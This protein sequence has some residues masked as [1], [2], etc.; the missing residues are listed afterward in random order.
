MTD[1]N[2]INQIRKKIGSDLLL[3][4]SVTSIVMDTQ[5]RILLVKDAD[6]GMWITPGG[7]VDPMESP[8]NAAVR[9]MWEETG[10]LLEPTRILGVYG[11]VDFMITYS[12]GDN[13]S[14]VLIAF[15][16]RVIGGIISPDGIET[17]EARYFSEINL[18][19]LKLPL[20]MQVVLSDAFNQSKVTHFKSPTWRP[21][22]M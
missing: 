15:M 11:G 19:E 3:L 1:M 22:G 13:V 8:A 18:A 14:Y 10:L 4:P 9:E 16:C 21:P 17:L 2:Y 12:N 5:N 20:W 6:S 7:C